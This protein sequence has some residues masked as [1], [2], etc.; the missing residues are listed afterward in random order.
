MPFRVTLLALTRRKTKNSD[1]V[2]AGFPGSDP[3]GF[4]DAGDEDLAVANAP[5]L[6]STTDRLDGFLDHV[7]AEHNLDLHLGEKIHDV[8]GPPVKF[9]MTLLAAEAFG[10]GHG[11]ALQ[12]DLLQGLF[13]LVELERFD[14]RLDLLH[15]FPSRRL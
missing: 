8:F 14:H 11:N 4:F 15:A 3:D 12:A 2:Q 7:V 6:G 5:G 9:G 10:F 1:R 13:H